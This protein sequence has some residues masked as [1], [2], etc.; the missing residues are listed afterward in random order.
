ME[1]C[2]DYITLGGKQ[3]AVP[4]YRFGDL[5]VV[6]TGAMPRIAQIKDEWYYEKAF[7]AEKIFGALKD[8]KA[9]ADLFTFAQRLP[10]IRQMH[11]YPCERDNYAALPI[12]AYE[13]WLERISS[14]E[15]RAISR[16][17][18]MGLKVDIASFDD[19]LIRGITKIYNETPIRQG[20]KFW[21]YGEDYEKVKRVNETYPD[22][23]V[24]L[25]AWLDNELVG[26]IK[27][28]SSGNLA[29]TMQIISKNA[30]RDKSPTTMLIAGAVELCYK[31]GLEY[32]VYGK[33]TYDEEEEESGLSEFKRH[34]GFKRFDIPRYYIPL[35]ARGTLSLKTGLHHGAKS[36]IPSPLK[37]RIKT[38]RTTVYN[39]IYQR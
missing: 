33:Y 17:R 34:N 8:A 18:D 19:R 7:D 36:L 38:I 1:R 12:T 30:H 15:R 2:E 39:R 14:K 32:L 5:F 4:A 26:F 21:H 27:L 35:N 13:T 6:I 22:R 31:R 9:P 20:R 11:S 16:A 24:F 28:V 29:R 25:G 23:A 3:M 10:D 37:S